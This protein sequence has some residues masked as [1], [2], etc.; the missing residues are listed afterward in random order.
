[1]SQ[2]DRRDPR[3]APRR[4]SSPR[5]SKGLHDYRDD[6]D[7]LPKPAL[8]DTAVELVVT[9][10]ATALVFFLIIVGVRLWG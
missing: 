9:L 10:A 1:M 6:Y 5:G 3:A 7:D 2:N 4:D 8:K